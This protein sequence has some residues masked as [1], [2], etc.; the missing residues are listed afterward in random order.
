MRVVSDFLDRV[1]TRAVGSA[2]MLSP[3]LPSLFEP[4]GRGGAAVAEESFQV[5]AAV[6]GE[7]APTPALPNERQPEGRVVT[8]QAPNPALA[9]R[10]A[11]EP[12][13][14]AAPRERL[15]VVDD[16]QPPVAHKP[17]REPAPELATPR[18]TKRVERAPAGELQ[19]VRETHVLHEWIIA[20]P[21]HDEPLGV[22]L[23][24]GQPVFATRHDPVA[25]PATPARQPSI[26]QLADAP[27][28]VREPVVHVSIGRLEVR[29]APAG[30]PAPRR[31]EAP[32]ASTLDDYLRQRGGS[33][34]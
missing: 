12:S 1:A 15:V 13:M 5:Q 24:P 3:R 32:R 27:G 14:Q 7:R 19:P 30:A 31:Q 4:A 2:S 28:A 10:P 23:P 6:P 26:A 8:P 34:P 11:K 17:P 20:E 33:T 25:R 29:A 18:V 22:L 16:P 21:T 9:P